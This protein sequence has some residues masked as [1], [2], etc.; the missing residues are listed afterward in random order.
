M[1]IGQIKKYVKENQY[2]SSLNKKYILDY[3]KYTRKLDFILEKHFYDFIDPCLIGNEKE[4]FFFGLGI[5]KKEKKTRVYQKFDFTE[6]RIMPG[7]DFIVSNSERLRDVLSKKQICFQTSFQNLPRILNSN[8]FIHPEK[9]PKVFFLNNKRYVLSVVKEGNQRI[10]DIKL[11]IDMISGCDWLA[12][13]EI[14]VVHTDGNYWMVTSWEGKAVEDDIKENNTIDIELFVKRVKEICSLMYSKKVLWFSL[15]PRNLVMK[16]DRLIIIDFEKVYPLD[17]VSDEEQHKFGE[18]MKIWFQ[19]IFSDEIVSDIFLNKKIQYDYA[20]ADEFEYK[21]FGLDRISYSQRQ[22]LFDLTKGV[23]RLSYLRSNPIYGHQ[24]GQYISDFLRVDY[25]ILIHKLSSE[26]GHMDFKIIKFIFFEIAKVEYF[27]LCFF[28]QKNKIFDDFSFII[29]EGLNLDQIEVLKISTKYLEKKD[30]DFFQKNALVKTLFEILRIGENN[31]SVYRNCDKLFALK[32]KHIAKSEE[33]FDDLVSKGLINSQSIHRFNINLLR[34]VYRLIDTVDR[35]RSDFVFVLTGSYVYGNVHLFSDFDGYFFFKNQWG[36]KESL[37]YKDYLKILGFFVNQNFLPIIN[38]HFQYERLKKM[39]TEK[40][41]VIEYERNE[42]TEKTEKQTMK[43]LDTYVDYS[44]DTFL[45]FKKA[46]F[47]SIERGKPLIDKR[48]IG[49]EIF[50]FDTIFICGNKSIYNKWRKEFNDG[51]FN[52]LK[53]SRN[54]SFVLDEISRYISGPHLKRT[55]YLK[56]FGN[57]VYICLYILFWSQKIKKLEISRVDEITR[58]TDV[59]NSTLCL[60]VL[61]DI[62]NINH[63]YVFDREFQINMKKLSF[64]SE[65]KHRKLASEVDRFD[66]F[67]K[68]QVYKIWA[69]K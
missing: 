42:W 46:L 30:L 62:N 61:E 27:F 6:N 44:P 10:E 24:L 52:V 43:I 21:W 22:K 26:M 40:G 63:L 1:T 5:L 17:E 57:S 18:F 38:Q 49:N 37:E 68:R 36:R 65:I 67:L 29:K 25:D 11:L 13:P 28:L 2:I 41:V 47:S 4:D 69:N 31:T 64:L 60:E 15:A 16:E 23:E 12:L 58:F 33:W 3:L 51:A 9:G 54:S 7:V 34:K 32:F 53:M 50:G 59:L 35:K 56:G 39:A 8:N 66:R 19:D 20:Q 45:K 14:A 48:L 55:K